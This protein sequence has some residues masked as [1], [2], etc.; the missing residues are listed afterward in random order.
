[1]PIREALPDVTFSG[2]FEKDTM[3]GT[4]SVLYLD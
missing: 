3:K 1:M 4:I 2:T